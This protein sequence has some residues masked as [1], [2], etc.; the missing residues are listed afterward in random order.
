MKN[1][2]G[3]QRSPLLFIYGCVLGLM[4]CSACTSAPKSPPTKVEFERTSR[5]PLE[6]WPQFADHG[7][8]S[9]L[10]R[11]IDRQVDWFDRNQPDKSWD[12]AGAKRNWRDMRD[13]LVV[14]RDVVV[15]CDGDLTC[16]QNRLER[17]FELYQMTL[18]NG[19][20]ILVTGYHAPVFRGSLTPS[21]R[22]R[23]P[24]YR[25]PGDLVQIAAGEYDPQILKVGERL[26]RGIVYGRYDADSHS[27]RPY[28]TRAEIDLEKALEGRDL[29]IA[30]LES[31]MDQFLFHVQGGG[32][33][34]LDKGG[35]IK[36]DFAGKNGWPYRSIGRALVDEGR[37][38]KD[39]ISIPAIKQYFSN[40]P[41]E[42][43]RVCML[44]ASYV[45]YTWDGQVH[46][47]L[48]HDIFP[49]G[50]LGFPVTPKRSIA[51]DKR[52]FAGGGLAWLSARQRDGEGETRP[53]SG[54]VIDQDT[55][56]AIQGAH[57]D[58]FLGAGPE[59]E[60][61]AGLLLDEGGQVYFLVARP[62]RI[63]AMR[64]AR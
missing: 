21:E 13:S 14:F 7:D 55:G 54:F 38:P 36:V 23:F 9:S 45:F 10:L 59:A 41:G 31:Y 32:F 30:Y 49:H 60:K 62:E 24:L 46:E 50:V 25:K 15:A 29:E 22:Y 5:V 19:G 42:E 12:F 57:I 51:T 16:L 53:F 26:V 33:I 34:Q 35:V 11:A 56:G 43:Q 2:L 58:F 47:G 27:V 64:Q 1:L 20:D 44:N 28:F 18:E 52:L 6:K 8:Q 48:N 3:A 40:H 4:W 37:I 39:E 61:D 17:D 63:D